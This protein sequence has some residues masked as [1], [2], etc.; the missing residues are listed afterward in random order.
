MSIPH[1][2]EILLNNRVSIDR[3]LNASLNILNWEPKAI[4][5]IT[6]YLGMADPLHYVGPNSAVR[7]LRI[8]A[9]DGFSQVWVSFTQQIL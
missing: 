7:E 8:R 1:E 4:G 9:K 3:D 6:V 2:V 5:A